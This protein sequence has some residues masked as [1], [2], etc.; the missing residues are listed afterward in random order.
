MLR[1]Y[2]CPAG[3][4]SIGYGATKFRGRDVIPSDTC[5]EEEAEALLNLEILNV[6]RA[7]KKVIQVPVKDH[8]LAAMISLTYNIGS[9]AFAASTLL[10]LLNAGAPAALVA[11]QFTRWNKSGSKVLPGL[12]TRRAE[13]K[14]LFL[15]AKV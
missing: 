15:N 11:E 9:G 8:E 7:I 3:V 14:E 6:T 1:A 2:L 10:R 12:V 5:T 4:W 13:E